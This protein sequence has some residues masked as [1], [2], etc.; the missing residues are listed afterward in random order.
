MIKKFILAY[1]LSILLLILTPSYIFSMGFKENELNGNNL[2][3]E[4]DFEG[5]SLEYTE[6][7]TKKADYKL[8]YNRGVSYYKLGQYDKSFSDFENSATYANSEGDQIK[9]VYNAGNSNYMMAETV[10][11]ENPGQALELFGKAVNHYERVLELDT[12]NDD[13]SYNL[14]LARLRLDE[15][16]QQ[17]S[18]DQQSEDQPDGDQQSDNGSED[19]QQDGEQQNSDQQQQDQQI[20][21]SESSYLSEE[22]SPKDILNEEARRQDA[23]Q[24]LIT[25]GSGELV[26]KDW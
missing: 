14:E 25:S 17:Q 24:A 1:L 2:Y 3:K 20:E 15:I 7:L 4:D 11:N 6:G 18:E 8:Y 10:K 5:A 13:A 22:I 21:S 16:K 23:I 12:D 19:G 9:A 26:D